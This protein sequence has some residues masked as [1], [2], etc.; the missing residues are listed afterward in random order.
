MGDSTVNRGFSMAGTLFACS[1]VCAM[2]FVGVGTWATQSGVS[3]QDDS[4]AHIWAEQLVDSQL[5]GRRLGRDDGRAPARV[6]LTHF[7]EGQPRVSDY[8]WKIYANDVAGGHEQFRVEVSWEQA[9][10]WRTLSV[11]R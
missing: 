9:G 8:F 2:A 1:I 10:R 7:E 3:A 6:R 4:L 5:T 11:T